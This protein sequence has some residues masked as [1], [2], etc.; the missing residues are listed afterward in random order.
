MESTKQT[1]HDASQHAT[2]NTWFFAWYVHI[3]TGWWFQI[4]IIVVPIWG[5]MIQFDDHIS[6]MG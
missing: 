3:F 2:T 1:G 6:L 4:F 5:F